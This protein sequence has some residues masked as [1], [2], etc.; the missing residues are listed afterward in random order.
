MVAMSQPMMS[1][2]PKKK[3]LKKA[4]CDRLLRRVLMMMYLVNVCIM[5][6]VTY[7][8]VITTSSAARLLAIRRRYGDNIEKILD[9]IYVRNNAYGRVICETRLCHEC[10]VE[11]R[12]GDR[13]DHQ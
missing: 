11:L 2:Q 10:N 7:L 12:F 5:V 13:H 3:P 8:C 9:F 4:L 1:T 6:Y